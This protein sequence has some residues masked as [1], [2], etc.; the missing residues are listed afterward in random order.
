MENK[1]INHRI[2]MLYRQLGKSVFEADLLVEYL[3]KEQKKL[4]KSIEKAIHSIEKSENINGHV[5][6]QSLVVDESGSS[7]SK[8]V[9]EGLS[10]LPENAR[11]L[12]PEKNENGIYVYRFCKQC[13]VG[14][15]PESTHCSH[16]HEAL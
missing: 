16:C 12:T 10:E 5:T 3:S 11:I 6:E 15:H 1:T 7:S 9:K 2:N 14:N 4:V 8:E 13:H